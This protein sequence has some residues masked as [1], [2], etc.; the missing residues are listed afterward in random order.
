MS[1]WHPIAGRFLHFCPFTESLLDEH[2]DEI[3]HCRCYTLRD[4]F[5]AQDKRAVEID[6]ER[7]HG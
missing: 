2:D 1:E 4:F 7:N 3:V 5:D 6:T